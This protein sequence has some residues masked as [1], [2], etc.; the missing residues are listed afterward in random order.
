M[1]HSAKMR[2]QSPSGSVGRCEGTTV[3]MKG[4]GNGPIDAALDALGRPAVLQSYEERA[5]SGGS[6][7][8]AVAFVEMSVPGV[9]G[10]TFGAGVHENIVTASLLAL[11]S[12][13][14]RL[15]ARIAASDRTVDRMV[16]RPAAA[17]MAA[18]A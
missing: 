16:D 10:S 8:R 12:G 2:P 7:A 15:S 6:A 3:V 4:Q 18:T 13:Y 11:V 5:L 9:A 17:E 1:W 14:N